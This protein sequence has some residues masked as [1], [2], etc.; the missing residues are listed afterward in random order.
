[1]FSRERTPV[2]RPSRRPPRVLHM[3]HVRWFNAEAQYALDL[4][5]EMRRQGV[6]TVYLAQ[7]GSP[8]AERAREMGVPVVEEAGF[9]AKGLRAATALAAAARL[10]QLLRWGGFDAVEVHR[11]EG[12]PLIAWACRRAGVPVVRVRGDMRPVRADPLNRRVY[13]RLL[14]GVVASNTAIE[15]HLRQRLGPGLRVTTIHGGVDPARFTPHGPVADVRTELG[16]PPGA[17]LVGILGRLGRVKGHDDFLAAAREAT[18]QAPDARYAVLVKEPGTRE[19]ELRRQVAS[20]PVLRG[21]VG[22][23]GHRQDLPA[24][25]RAFDLAVVASIGSEANCRVGLEWMASG[26]PLLATRVGVLPDLVEPGR[27]GFLVPPAEPSALAAKIVYLAARR[28]EARM[29]GDAARRRVL[30][31]FTLER[32]AGL[33]L[34][35]LFPDRPCP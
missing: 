2:P 21:R 23:L 34:S 32:C 35:F 14:R 22:F 24:V 15:R 10:R 29:M 8:A 3:A 20:D 16:F 4:A 27:T 26:V 6:E 12:L 25:L 18:R 28:S 19:A 17:F 11:P 9:N 13:T 7:S 1:M 33:H 5:A 31:R 30:D